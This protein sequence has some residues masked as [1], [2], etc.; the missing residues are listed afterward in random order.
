MACQI[1]HQNDHKRGRCPYAPDIVATPR[2]S[3]RLWIGSIIAL[4]TALVGL[5]VYRSKAPSLNSNDSDSQSETAPAT[6]TTAVVRVPRG[7]P[8][9]GLRSTRRRDNEE[10]IIEVLG[11]GTSVEVLGKVGE[12]V[13]ARSPKGKTGWINRDSLISRSE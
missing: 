12:W 2:G 5:G 9:V 7:R 6:P 1:C 4:L 10:N 3:L 8:G 11:D 13:R